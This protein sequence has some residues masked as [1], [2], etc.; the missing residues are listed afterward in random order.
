MLDKLQSTDFS[1]FLNEPFLVHYGAPEPLVLTLIK[2]DEF[3]AR[4]HLDYAGRVGFSLL[5]RGP[6]HGYLIQHTYEIEHPKLGKLEL[7]MVPLGPDGE[8]MLYE[9]IFN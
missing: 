3:P 7:F 5:F 8:G 9:I 1:P 2:V 6:G 4:F